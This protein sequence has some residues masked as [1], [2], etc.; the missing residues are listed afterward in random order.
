MAASRVKE[1]LDELASTL[2]ELGMLDEAGE[3]EEANENQDGTPADGEGTR[4]VLE[5]AEQRQ[6]K[7]DALI[8]KAE[9][10]KDAIAKAEAAEARKN[11]LLRVFNKATPAT[12][13]ADMKPKTSIYPVSRRGILRAFDDYETAYKCG[14]WLKASGGDAEAKR[15]CRDAGI[16]VRDMGEQV[17]SL[18]GVTV[19]ESF[20]NTLIRRVEQYGVAANISQKITM[21]TDTVLVPRRLTGV[22]ATWIGENTSIPTSDPTATMVQLVAKKLAVATRVSMELMADSAMV[23]DWLLAEFSL[24]IAKQIDDAVFLGNGS[25]DY[26]GIRG[27]AQLTDGTHAASVVTAAT[28]NTT[29]ASLDIDDFTKALAS[30]PRYAIGTSA[31]YMHHQVYHQAVQRLMLSTGTAG[32]GVVGALAGGNTAANLAQSTPTTF[33]GLPVVWVLSMNSAPTSGQVCAYVGDVSLA[34][35]MGEKAGGVQIA[36]SDD[37]YFEYDQRV[38]KCSYRMDWNMHTA[39]DATTP[40]PVIALKL[41]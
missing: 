25:S 40:G 28:G 23:A 1:L 15:W 14:Q 5:Q 31:W 39:G 8:A 35:I 16:E 34:S 20:E 3:A 17:N 7:Y 37:R 36:F 32:T 6:A 13:S 12:E 19:F 27:L 41:A 26:G 30:V 18:G 10:I 33:L 21:P 29:L 4:S 9:R 38:Y 24:A 22:T 2:A 11:D